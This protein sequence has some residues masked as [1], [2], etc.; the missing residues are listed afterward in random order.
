MASM[1]NLNR[2]KFEKCN[3]KVI[4]VPLKKFSK[5]FKVRFFYGGF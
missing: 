3:G 1:K 2:V 5:D 4:F